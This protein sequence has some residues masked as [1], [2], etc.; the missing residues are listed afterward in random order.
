MNS[1]SQR[2]GIKP[3]KKIQIDSM[4]DDLRTG[5]W[6]ALYVHCLNKIYDKELFRILWDKH[7]KR[8]LDTL[9]H[10]L[11]DIYDDIRDHFFECEWNE[12]YDFI[13]FVSNNYPDKRA[14]RQFIKHCNTVLERESSAYRFVGGK[15]TPITSEVEISA[16]KEA[17]K[18]PIDPVREHI[19]CSLELFSDRKKPDYRNSIKEAISAVECLCKLISGN[20]KAELK[21]ALIEIEKKVPFHKSFKSALLK[22]YGYVSDADGIRHALLEQSNLSSEDARF[23][24]VICSAFV[25]YLLE[26]AS[27][28][29]IEL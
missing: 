1:F 15:I 4:D 16:I 22:L 8:L 23:M 6:N 3:I 12:V 25:N 9:P 20:P 7:L 26:K 14:N 24:L 11:E 2:R 18:V 5:L 27:K 10:L 13:E 21:H 19:N 29:G 17:I 28:A